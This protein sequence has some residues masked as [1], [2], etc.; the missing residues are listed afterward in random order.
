MKLNGTKDSHIQIP[1]SLLK[2]F[3]SPHYFKNI[4][5]KDEKPNMVYKLDMEGN[6]TLVNIKTENT[7]KGYYEDEIEST[8]LPSIEKKFGLLKE[9]ILDFIKGKELIITYD[10]ILTVKKFCSLCMVRSKS[11][12]ND[13]VKISRFIDVYENT[14]ANVVLYNYWKKPELVDKYITGN[15]ISFIKNET[16]INYL[17]PRFY[18]VGIK[19]DN[20]IE[21]YLI[22]ISPKILIRLTTDKTNEDNVLFSGRMKISDVDNFNKLS[23]KREYENNHCAIYAKNKEDLERYLDYLKELKIEN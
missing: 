6:I 3:S 13:I 15:N 9:K 21:D 19:Q 7:E 16:D 1:K 23:I 11:F 5:G 12:V 14:P 18:V 20:G 10:D 17:L 8:F 22:P 2:G 4:L